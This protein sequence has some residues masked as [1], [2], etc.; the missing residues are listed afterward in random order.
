MSSSDYLAKQDQS[1]PTADQRAVLEEYLFTAVHDHW[2]VSNEYEICKAK[3]QSLQTE[4]G[5]LSSIAGSFMEERFDYMSCSI[6][7]NCPEINAKMVNNMRQYSIA[8]LHSL[9]GMVSDKNCIF[10]GG[11]LLEE[12]RIKRLEAMM[13][14]VIS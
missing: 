7:E 10:L 14:Y 9:I 12:N 4:T 11:I 5:T 6:I 13:R 2:A 8:Q 3:R 1:F